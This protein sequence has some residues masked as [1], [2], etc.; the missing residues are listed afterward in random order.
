MHLIQPRPFNVRQTLIPGTV[1]LLLI[2]GVLT[3]DPAGPDY[4]HWRGYTMG[5]HYD[6]QI[7]ASTLSQAEAR[8]LERGIKDYLRQ[9]NQQMST[10]LTDSEISRFNETSATPPFPVSPSFR[11]VVE[12]ALHWGAASDGAFDPTLD[13]LIELWGF[14]RQ[15]P[16]TDWPTEDDIRAALARTGYDR[17]QIPDDAHIRKVDPQVRISLNAIAK[18]YAV[19][20]VGT[21]IE[22]AG[23]TNWYVEIGG[24]LAVSGVNRTGDPWRIGVELP[25]AKAGRG[26]AL[27]GIAHI[28]EG[29]LA[30]S[31]VYR[32]WHTMADGRRYS[33]IID[34][35][36][37]YPTDHDLVAV[38]VWAPRCVDADAVATA[39]IVM[40][41]DE[42]MAWV[43][44]LAQVEALFFQQAEGG[45]FRSS[46]SSGFSARTG[47]E[48]LAK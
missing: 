8:E 4:L 3:R 23:P 1:I 30:G 25:A 44:T 40:G 36:T 41:R 6:V 19:D 16:L 27:Y 20:G 9:I 2:F 31:G 22:Q 17:L 5:T 24:D 43:E 21:L 10:Y 37:G 11:R 39:L 12:R 48:P 29:S 13:P 42:G 28:T 14:G 35:R 46:A 38:H 33:H 34:P 45:E 32:Q 15:E 26:E 18:G 7:A 47:L